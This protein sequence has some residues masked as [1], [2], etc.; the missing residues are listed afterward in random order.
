MLHLAF[1][2]SN[3]AS[4]FPA[5]V[6][7]KQ[8]PAQVAASLPSDFSQNTSTVSSDT[9]IDSGEASH[10]GPGMAPAPQ[11]QP[12]ANPAPQQPQ[13][14]VPQFQQQAPIEQPLP[15]VLQPQQQPAA[16][17][18]APVQSDPLAAM[19]ASMRVAF[20]GESP[21]QIAK[22]VADALTPAVPVQ[23]EPVIDPDAARV[24]E[25]GTQLATLRKQ[26]AEEGTSDFDAEINSLEHEQ[27]KLETR[28]EVRNELQEDR[29]VT[30]FAQQ[31][32]QWESLANQAFP[33][34]DN[35][36]S[37]LKAAVDKKLSQILYGDEHTPPD[38]DYFTRSPDAG[39]SLV[40]SEA[41]KL[42]IAPK[43]VQQGAAP[44]PGMPQHITVP[45]AMPGS[46]QASHRPSSQVQPS[47]QAAFAA[48]LAAAEQHGFAGELALA[49]Q[50]ARGGFTGDGVQFVS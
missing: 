45:V 5:P 26:A 34:A 35:P 3:T 38:P 12:Q 46:M 22:R 28:L 27:L 8:T 33:D 18:Q 2:L 21:A 9:M 16:P 20:P 24:E 48:Q 50:M 1:P 39:Y 25:I 10:D 17:V 4:D 32:N 47:P 49:R 41:A 15:S 13:Q 37:P 29:R 11:D 40:A 44:A 42:G 31:A 30:E 6:A 7:A 14:P 23:Q 36:S 43:V 19:T